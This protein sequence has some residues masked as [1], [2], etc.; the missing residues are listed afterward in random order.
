MPEPKSKV[1]N[2]VG[3][4]KNIETIDGGEFM[5]MA[6]HILETNTIIFLHRIL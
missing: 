3:E 4:T 2:Y 1:Y 6:E 5:F